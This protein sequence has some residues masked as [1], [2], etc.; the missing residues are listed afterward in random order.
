MEIDHIKK[1]SSATYQQKKRLNKKGKQITQTGN[2]QTQIVEDMI[3][4]IGTIR[5]ICILIFIF[6]TSFRV[7][8]FDTHEDVSGSYSGRL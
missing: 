4:N 6:D 7:H 2:I 5:V 8:H 1:E 3:W